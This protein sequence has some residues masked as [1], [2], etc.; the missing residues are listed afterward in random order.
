MF[1]DES[2]I[3]LSYARLYARSNRGE[4]VIG[5]VPKNWGDGI[6]L[7]AGIGM[8]G[9]VAPMLLCGSMTG[10]IFETYMSESVLPVLQPHDVVVLDNLAAHKRKS[11]CSR[12]ESV[13]ATVLYLPP[14]CPELNPIEL[15]WSKLKTLV[16]AKAPRTVDALVDAVADAFR[17]ISLDEIY[18]WIQHCGYSINP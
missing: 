3:N 13:G 10:D 8:R 6:T 11:F 5:Q 17:S 16:R 2:G 14:Y 18:H 4:R 1:F 12:V 9:L 15:T 7:I